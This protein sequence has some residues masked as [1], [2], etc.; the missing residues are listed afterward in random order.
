[1]DETLSQ[2]EIDAL[3][4]HLHNEESVSELIK[5]D[6]QSVA[7][8][9]NFRRPN[10]FTKDQL[11][12]LYM[13]N[14][15]F[16][17]IISNYLSG[18]LRSSINIKIASVE[19]VTYEEFLVS[20]FSPTLLTVFQMPPLEGSAVLET[21]HNFTSPAVDLLFGGSGKS[22][23]K[24]RELTEIEVRVLKKLI[25]NLLDNMALAWSD[26]FKFNIT[27]ESTESNPQYNQIIS[28]NETVAII[29]F[30]AEIG[31][32]Q[33]IINICLPHATLKEAIP[34]LTAQNWFASQQGGD[35]SQVR[36]VENRLGKVSLDL[37]ACCGETQL[38]IH[39]FLQL[40][41][42]D[43]VLLDTVVGGDMQL[44]IEDQPKFSF[45]PGVVGEQ[46]AAMITGKI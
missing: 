6:K 29:T 31:K 2:S 44:L 16:S 35:I 37:T 21:S 30:T 11:R 27:I 17:R 25:K 38:T 24:V 8:K 15:N 1:M 34:N 10:K 12:T 19:Q 7:K 39:E 42:G 23:N 43:V 46:L 26:V 18:Y 40:E 32:T 41:E 3:I 20:I 45:Q 9:Y 14:E 5:D 4:N 13:I 36:T 33:S 22:T 28:P